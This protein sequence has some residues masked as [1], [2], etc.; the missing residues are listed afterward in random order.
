MQTKQQTMY[1][2]ASIA[3]LVSAAFVWRASANA[4]RPPAQP[5]AIAVID[6]VDIIEGLNER[7]VLESQL[8]LRMEARQAQLKEV[9]EELKTLEADVQMLTRGTDEYREKLREGVEKQAVANARREA[10]AQIESIDMGSVMAGLYAK[11]E[12]A[13]AD[14]SEREG[15]DIVLLDD[16]E[17][18]IPE[19]APN[20]DVYRAIVTRSVVY[21]HDSID[22]TDQVITLMNNEFS[23]P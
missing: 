18:T 23:A 21:R 3:I 19:G 20:P 15:Y 22:I 17:F 12:A 1:L 10:L 6:I 13:I 9:I 8:N 4:S 5:T 7:E 16:S 11:I 14:I 2:F